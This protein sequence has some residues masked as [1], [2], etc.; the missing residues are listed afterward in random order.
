M[1]TKNKDNRI[2]YVKPKVLDLGPAASVFG[3]EDCAPGTNPS[4]TG[5][6]VGVGASGNCSSTGT[7][8]SCVAPGSIA[9]TR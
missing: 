2:Q 5:C 1:K 8:A 7:G 3:A 4:G 9:G 6:T